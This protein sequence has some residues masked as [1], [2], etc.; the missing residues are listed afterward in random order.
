M[1]NKSHTPSH[2]ILKFQN[3]GDEEKCLKTP[4]EKNPNDKEN[5]IFFNNETGS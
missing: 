3:T 2:A 1:N 5:T 4:R